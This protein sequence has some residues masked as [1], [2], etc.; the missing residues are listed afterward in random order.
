MWTHDPLE[1]AKAAARIARTRQRN[2]PAAKVK[3]SAYWQLYVQRPN[4]RARRADAQR[5]RRAALKIT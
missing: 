2:K 5:R 1:E 3:A 4:V